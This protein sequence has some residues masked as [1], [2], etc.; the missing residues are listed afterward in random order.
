MKML[1]WLSAAATLAFT[2]VAANEP[3]DVQRARLSEECGR[4]AM[5]GNRVG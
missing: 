1:L 2:C 5:E 4:P 3:V